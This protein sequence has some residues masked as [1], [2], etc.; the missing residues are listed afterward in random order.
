MGHDGVYEHMRELAY[1]GGVGRGPFAMSPYRADTILHA[2]RR[3]VDVRAT[4]LRIAV[5]TSASYPAE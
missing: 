2:H 4:V 5:C 1:E 3:T